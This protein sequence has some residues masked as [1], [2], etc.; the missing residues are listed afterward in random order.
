[1]ELQVSSK[2][3]LDAFNACLKSVR[4]FS[5]LAVHCVFEV[6]RF[7]NRIEVLYCRVKS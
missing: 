5:F 2:L 4:R 1:M 7:L 3:S 6:I